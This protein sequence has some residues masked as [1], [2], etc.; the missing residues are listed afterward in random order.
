M[1]ASCD[2]ITTVILP[3][4]SVLL[5]TKLIHIINTLQYICIALICKNILSLIHSI[6]HIP[7]H[8]IVCGGRRRSLRS[9]SSLYYPLN[10]TLLWCHLE[11]RLQ[12]WQHYDDLRRD[13]YVKTNHKYTY[14][15]IHIIVSSKHLLH[16]RNNKYSHHHVNKIDKHYLVFNAIPIYYWC[17]LS[18]VLK[19]LP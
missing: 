15:W 5:K 14:I 4:W 1:S 7:S 18:R 19:Y 16:T 2:S 9:K 13:T 17:T 11:K 3:I 8:Q 10:L 12:S 6:H